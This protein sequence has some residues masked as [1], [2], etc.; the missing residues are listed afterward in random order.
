MRSHEGLCCLLW[1][2]TVCHIS[3]VTQNRQYFRSVRG[4][5]KRSR[6]A[7]A[8]Q[9]ALD[10]GQKNCEMKKDSALSG[11]GTSSERVHHRNGTI[12]GSADLQS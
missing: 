2:R 9:G 3:S 1:R 6:N 11:M 5:S 10:A 7:T 4:P 8:Q 12:S